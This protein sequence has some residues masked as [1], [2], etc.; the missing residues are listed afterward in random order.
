MPQHAEF[1]PH[2]SAGALGVK[3]DFETSIE[4]A[5]EFG[6]TSLDPDVAYLKAL[7]D[8]A[9]TE[10]LA[11]LRDRG[12]RLGPTGPGVDF[13]ADAAKF[14]E[15]LAGLSEYGELLQSLGIDRVGTWIKPWSDVT[16]RRNFARH[17]ERIGLAAEILSANGIR[18]GL[19]Y[20]G[21]KTLWSRDAYPFIHTLREALELLA[22]VGND[23][24]GVVLD[25]Y[26]WFSSGETAEDVAALR[27]EQVI[28]VD[29]NDAIAGVPVDE[30]I[31]GTR[32][33]PGATGVIDNAALLGALVQIGYQG[34]VK[35]E[36]F[37]AELR[38]KPAKEAVQLAADSL[39]KVLSSAS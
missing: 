12:L 24:V 25:S 38:A 27:P 14:G 16:Y 30:L 29:M 37:N 17:V 20:V 2:L 11:S 34:P 18:L 22:A 1:W 33:L 28:A 4:W 21:P 5:S 26:H 13:N 36:P 8:A 6:Y 19:E 10:F 23:H 32:E 39:H 3:V 15:Q 35:V 31:D 9:R 7:D